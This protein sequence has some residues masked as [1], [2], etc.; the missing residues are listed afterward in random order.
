MSWTTV[1]GGGSSVWTLN[2]TN[3]YYNSGNVGIGTTSPGY[4]LDVNGDINM[5]TGSSFR[6]NGV[7]QTF[8]GG[9]GSS[10]WTTSGSDI[11]YSSGNVGINVTSPT[12]VLDVDGKIKATQG[13]IG[14]GTEI[15]GLDLNHITGFTSSATGV[16]GSTTNDMEMGVFPTSGSSPALWP[17]GPMTSNTTGVSG[18]TLSASYNA[19]DVWRAF[20]DNTTNNSTNRW[21][22]ATNTVY[23]NDV[24]AHGGNLIRGDYLG[25]VE[26]ITGYIGE[27]FE[28]QM[29]SQIF[30][31]KLEIY[32]NQSLFLPRLLYVLGSNDC[33]QYQLIHTANRGSLCG[34]SSVY[35]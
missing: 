11:Y 14:N 3:A 34:S 2:G 9:G 6:I 28:V 30:I 10:P 16:A 26:R 13:F 1:S 19:S 7:A 8:G 4:K 17:N 32:A 35:N 5:S 12:E 27:W 24:T 15:T 20:N 33:I 23:V 18:Y 22:F 21:Q 25:S 31:Q 29:P